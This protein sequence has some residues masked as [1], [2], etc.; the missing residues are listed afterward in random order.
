MVT[1]CYDLKYK[2]PQL[3][4]RDTEYISKNEMT[5]KIEM[6]VEEGIEEEAFLDSIEVIEVVESLY[7]EAPL[8]ALIGS[9]G[10]GSMYLGFAMEHREQV[11][12]Y[13]FFSR[14]NLAIPQ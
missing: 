2:K 5:G 6:A 9:K 3:D 10:T 4:P 7:K 13:T 14:E 8:A 1:L 12:P 11:E